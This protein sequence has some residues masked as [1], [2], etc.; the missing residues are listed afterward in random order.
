MTNEKSAP[1]TS[2]ARLKIGCQYDCDPYTGEAYLSRISGHGVHAC[3]VMCAEA[4]DYERKM[5]HKVEAVE[6]EEASDG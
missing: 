4:R 1:A 6:E 2:S 3:F 5:G